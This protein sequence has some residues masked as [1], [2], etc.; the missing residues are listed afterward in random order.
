MIIMGIDP[1]TA[2][3]GYG[4]IEKTGGKLSYSDCGLIMPSGDNLRKRLRSLEIKLDSLIKKTK[5]NK[6]G[7]ENLFFSKNKK[8]AMDVAHARGIII[9]TLEKSGVE[10]IELSPLEVKLGVT[11]YGN[12][13]KKAVSGMVSKILGV[14]T[15]NIIDDA[16]DALAIAITTAYTKQVE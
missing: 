10:I 16:T 1:G 8:T 15:D 3:I 13:S 4:I 12:A 7:V 14:S 11:G 2:R 9:N 5:P 6:A